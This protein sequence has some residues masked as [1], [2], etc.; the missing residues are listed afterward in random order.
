MKEENDLGQRTKTFRAAH[1]SD[2]RGFAKTQPIGH[3]FPAVESAQQLNRIHQAQKPI[4]YL[5]A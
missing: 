5:G 1:Y 3:V 4:P 2:A